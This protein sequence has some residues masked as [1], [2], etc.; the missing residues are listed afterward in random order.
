M[1]GQL[2]QV[3]DWAIQEFQK[4]MPGGIISDDELSLMFKNLLT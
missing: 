4:L 1:S 3:K 2:D